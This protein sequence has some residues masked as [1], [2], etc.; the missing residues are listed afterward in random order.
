MQ[1]TFP[2][3]INLYSSLHLEVGRKLAAISRSGCAWWCAVEFFRISIGGCF[4]FG[5]GGGV[6]RIMIRIG[7]VH[8]GLGWGI[9]MMGERE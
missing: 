5:E 2:Q 9:G 3:C 4:F 6:V 8:W 1:G 7:T